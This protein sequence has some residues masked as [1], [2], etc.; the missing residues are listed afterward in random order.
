MTPDRLVRIQILHIANCARLDSAR[1]I[2]ALAVADLGDTVVV[3]EI[4]GAFPSP[5]VLIDGVDATGHSAGEGV[6]CRLDLPTAAQV[7][8]A[9]LSAV[10][11]TGEVRR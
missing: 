3:E 10:G 9:V 5:T 4:E 8:A 1:A 7:R 6:A 2:V 11:V